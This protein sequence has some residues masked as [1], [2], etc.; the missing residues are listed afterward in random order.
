MIQSICTFGYR[1]QKWKPSKIS[2]HLILKAFIFRHSPVPFDFI[3]MLYKAVAVRQL[4]TRSHYS[5]TRFVNRFSD[6]YRALSLARAHQAPEYDTYDWCWY[7][8]RPSIFVSRF[9]EA[10]HYAI[11][12]GYVMLWC[13]EMLRSVMCED[14]GVSAVYFWVNDRLTACWCWGV[15]FGWYPVCVDIVKLKCFCHGCDIYVMWAVR[16]DSRYA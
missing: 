15:F 8:A 7:I 14:C 1:M 6:V 10:F 9:D 16:I 4:L 5:R 3:Q 13:V 11:V 12:L 2:R